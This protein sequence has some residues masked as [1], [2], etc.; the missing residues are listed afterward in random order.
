M[1][2]PRT[3]AALSLC[4]AVASGC[5]A[6]ATGPEPEPGA[7]TALLTARIVMIEVFNDCD[8]RLDNPGDFEAWVELWQDA[9]PSPAQAY[10]PLGESARP[11]I[12]LNRY[13][14]EELST[15]HTVS[16]T[17]YQD[18]GRPVMVRMGSR[19]LDD[20]RVEDSGTRA[21]ALFTWSESGRCW[22]YDHACIGPA[23]AARFARSFSAVVSTR[24]DEFSLFNSDDEGCRFTTTWDAAFVNALR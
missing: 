4:I 11:T 3:A 14:R 13:A 18:E 6:G 19:E 16:A 9:D 21:E 17:V 24:E 22:K 1:T 12:P 2:R 10:E 7:L 20:D 8:P 5:D 23:D 15:A